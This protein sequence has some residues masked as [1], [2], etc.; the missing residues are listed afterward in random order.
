MSSIKIG[1]CETDITPRRKI[2]LS[3]QFYERISEYV[4]SPLSVVGMA[5]S[6]GSEHAVICACDLEC[7]SAGLIELARRK[8]REKSCACGGPD[9][10][11]VMICATH[12]HTS[13]EYTLGAEGGSTLDVLTR[14]L[15]ETA[16][17]RAEYESNVD[18]AYAKDVMSGD[19]ALVFLADKIAENAL[20]AWKSMEDA[21]YIYA[22]GRA[23]VGMCRRAVYTDGTAKMWGDTDT[24]CFDSLEGGND[25]G[26]ELMYTFDGAG[27]P[28]GVIANVS[29]PAQ[30][31]EQRSFVSS[32]YWGKVREYTKKRFGEDFKV[33]GLCGAAG[34]QCPRDLVR[35]VEP[36]TPIDDPNVIRSDPKYRRA[37]PS[38]FD[39]A[40]CRKVGKRI[41]NEIACVFDDI[42]E[43]GAPYKKDGILLHSVLKLD[44]PLRRVTITEYENAKRELDAYVEKY[45]AKGGSS[46]AFTYTDKAAMHVCA[47]T[48]ARFAEQQDRDIYTSEV[49]VLRIDDSVFVTSPFE[50]FLDYG[51]RI[52]ARSGAAQ[53]FII[54]LC[55]GSGGYL[56]TEKAERGGHYSAYV[57]SGNAGHEGGDLLVRKTLDEIRRLTAE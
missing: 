35:W 27:N 51:N 16:P 34:D 50:L 20:N 55:C 2:K 44:L 48:V 26:I 39:I 10:E 9:P 4:E 54:Q 32:D 30:V 45:I 38:M 41:A 40:G 57:S 3:G 49:H 56:P 25:S 22:F 6:D 31:L 11:K 24:P 28:T 14:V 19:E 36:E 43:S 42:K 18:A 8:I 23:A 29:C 12:C 53:T 21:F 52:R 37:D 1:W 46:G 5:V 33:L 13:Y 15:S 17:G 47:G 7:V